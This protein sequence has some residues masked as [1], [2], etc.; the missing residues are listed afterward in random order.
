V[1]AQLNASSRASDAPCPSLKKRRSRRWQRSGVGR[2]RRQINESGDD[3]KGVDV[4]V[5]ICQGDD[6][7]GCRRLEKRQEINGE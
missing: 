1:P 5:L 6:G 3:E 7:G 4:R 2:A